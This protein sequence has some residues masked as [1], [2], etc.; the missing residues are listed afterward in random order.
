ME[1]QDIHKKDK[2]IKLYYDVPIQFGKDYIR[3][4]D[5]LISIK[6]KCTGAIYH[7]AEVNSRYRGLDIRFTL[8]CYSSDLITAL[9]REKNQRLREFYRYPAKKN[10]RK[11]RK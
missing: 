11:N 4:D 1:F 7:V 9:S 6:K 10:D 3:V 8:K 5:F 2:L